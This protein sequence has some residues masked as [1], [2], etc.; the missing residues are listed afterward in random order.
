M[1][2]KKDIISNQDILTF[3]SHIL[4]WFKKNK[5]DFP[6]RKYG[7]SNYKLIIAEILLQRTKAETISKFYDKFLSYYPSWKSLDNTR[8]A[9]LEKNLQPIGLYRQRAAL[10]KELAREMTKRN[11]RL[12]SKR[13]EIEKLP[14]AGQYI[15]NAIFLV[16]KN[17]TAPLLDVN[18][19]RVLER[20]FGPR[21][22][23]DIR[24]DPYL[25]DLAWRIV[26]HK[27]S[28]KINW[29]ILD[30]AALTCTAKNPECNNCLL[31]I[32]CRYFQKSLSRELP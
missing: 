24:Y 3:R 19:A 7:L 5:R 2:K 13:E 14:F 8:K 10:L 15:V 32:K 31:N 28:K 20:Y 30:F 21:K 12:P 22:L 27:E 18:M 9:T 29:G 6:W 16:I 1:E 25:Q 17:Q 23:A 4:K 11:G 26:E